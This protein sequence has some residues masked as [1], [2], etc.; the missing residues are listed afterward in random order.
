MHTPC[1]LYNGLGAFLL[2]INAQTHCV[3]IQG[4]E[5]W[6]KYSDQTKCLSV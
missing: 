6:K 4:T 1:K 5:P 2:P 3:V